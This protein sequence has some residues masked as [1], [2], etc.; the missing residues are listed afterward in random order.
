MKQHNWIIQLCDYHAAKFTA[1]HYVFAVIKDALQA[2]GSCH[3]C[4]LDMPTN[5]KK[6]DIMLIEDES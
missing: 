6:V 1:S 4:T 5:I 3:A 2:K